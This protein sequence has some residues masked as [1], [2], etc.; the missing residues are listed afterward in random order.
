MY[1]GYTREYLSSSEIH[2]EVFRDKGV[3]YPQ[4]TPISNGSRKKMC[5]PVCV[6]VCVCVCT[7]IYVR[8]Q[9]ER[10]REHVLTH[11]RG[12]SCNKC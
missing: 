8:I 9:R 4:L 3:W 5:E 12:T 7:H 11:E 10:E 6:C 2:T 1:S